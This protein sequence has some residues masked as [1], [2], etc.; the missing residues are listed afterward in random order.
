VPCVVEHIL[1]CIIIQNSITPSHH[2]FENYKIVLVNKNTLG[3][4]KN[5]TWG[6][7]NDNVIKV[8]FSNVLFW[9]GNDLGKKNYM[10]TSKHS[11]K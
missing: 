4:I 10:R 8:T 3:W 7:Y 2:K 1:K 9:G 6:I 5:N 11:R